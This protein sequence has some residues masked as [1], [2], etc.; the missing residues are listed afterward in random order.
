MGGRVAG[1]LSGLMNMGAQ[2]G[3]FITAIATAKVATEF[4]WT[5]SFITAAVICFIGAV[6][7]IFIDPHHDVQAKAATPPAKN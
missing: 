5:A 4:G 3:G 6:L 7:W 1:S 2:A